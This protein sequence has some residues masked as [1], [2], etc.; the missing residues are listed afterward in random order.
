M[1]EEEEAKLD[2]NGKKIK[3]LSVEQSIRDRFNGVNDSLAKKMITKM[4]K[5]EKPPPPENKSITTLFVGGVE[6][7]LSE[8]DIVDFF[9]KYGKVNGIRLREK[10]KCAFICFDER[11]AAEKAI[12]HLFSKLFIKDRRLKLLWAKDQLDP[13]KNKKRTR[14]EFKNPDGT[15]SH[16]PTKI[17]IEEKRDYYQAMDPS[18][19][20]GSIKKRDSKLERKDGEV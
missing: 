17:V 6:E 15:I 20:G 12:D 4:K 18:K 11:S 7:G 16:K 9:K 1:P 13:N 19:Y 8:Q 2:E 10:S 14:D 5:S 3:N